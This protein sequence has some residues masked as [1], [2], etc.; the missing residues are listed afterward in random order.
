MLP[1]GDY[2]RSL[3]LNTPKIPFPSG[4]FHSLLI[5][6]VFE[7]V[8]VDSENSLIRTDKTR[9]MICEHQQSRKRQHYQYVT[10]LNRIHD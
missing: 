3:N 1:E 9:Q 4:I 2:T 7:G 10:Q 8:E 6:T 5:Q